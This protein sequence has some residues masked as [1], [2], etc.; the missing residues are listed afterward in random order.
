MEI[1]RASE[2]LKRDRWRERRGKKKSTSNPIASPAKSEKRRALSRAQARFSLYRCSRSREISSQQQRSSS[3]DK[4]KRTSA[5]KEKRGGRREARKKSR[6][7]Q[8]P[9]RE[10]DERR[11]KKGRK[12]KDL[13]KTEVICFL[14]FFFLYSLSSS[15]PFYILAAAS[16]FALLSLSSASCASTNLSDLPSGS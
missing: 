16:L 2:F 3:T 4:A 7:Q 6:V 13:R 14:T 5:A 9:P 8:R 10:N 1:V 11:T 15:L 12:K